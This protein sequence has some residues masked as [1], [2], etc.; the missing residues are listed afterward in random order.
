MRYITFILIALLFVA[1]CKTKQKESED[2][3]SLVA[4]PQVKKDLKE[5]KE[6]GVL[7]ALVVYGGTSYFLYRG[8][9]MGY[10]YELLERF[11]DH[12]DVDTEVSFSQRIAWAVR[13]N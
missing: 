10:E 11:A 12:L 7:K 8:Q 1:G 13:E 3:D 9:A 5:I 6:D 4:D 2:K